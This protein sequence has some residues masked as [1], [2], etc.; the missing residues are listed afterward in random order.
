MVENLNSTDNLNE[1]MGNKSEDE[2]FYSLADLKEAHCLSKTS[3]F[4][5]KCTNKKDLGSNA[6]ENCLSKIACNSDSENTSKHSLIDMTG[7]ST[8]SSPFSLRPLLSVNT[9]VITSRN[10]E[11]TCPVT[12][13]DSDDE[14]YSLADLARK[15]KK[16]TKLNNKGYED[17][18]SHFQNYRKDAATVNHDVIEQI[19]PS[20]GD[21]KLEAVDS[22]KPKYNVSSNRNVESGIGY[23]LDTDSGKF[24]TISKSLSNNVLMNEHVKLQSD[25]SESDSDDEPS[26]SLADLAKQ[27]L[28]VEN[29]EKED[30][31]FAVDEE[32][33]CAETFSGR[34]LVYKSSSGA[35]RTVMCLPG[36]SEK[37]LYQQHNEITSNVS[38]TSDWTSDKNVRDY[39]VTHSHSLP[40]LPSGHSFRNVGKELDLLCSSFGRVKSYFKHHV[41]GGVSVGQKCDT[42]NS[43]SK[44]DISATESSRNCSESSDLFADEVDQMWFSEIYPSSLSTQKAVTLQNESKASNK[45]RADS[46]LDWDIDLSSAL[47]AVDLNPSNL[48]EVASDMESDIDNW[49]LPLFV[50]TSPIPKPVEECVLDNSV[51]LKAHLVLRTKCSSFGKVICKKWKVRRKPYIKIMTLQTSVKRFK[52]DK[53]SPDDEV[54]ELRKK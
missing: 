26:Y 14:Q 30:V 51:L 53:P 7:H 42:P 36:K 31:L 44:S 50:Q 10:C 12:S 48:Y 35:E 28:S 5:I 37:F 19:Q 4:A 17:L 18:C 8:L 47:K 52:F 2:L 27:H 9:H 46:S 24:Y 29:L 11:H 3:S 23:R 34:N 15:Y 13:S 25:H 41:S 1:F 32:F 20:F 21:L 43:L 45:H 22:C 16:V 49:T 40:N 33:G 39:F 38:N 6:Y 54:L